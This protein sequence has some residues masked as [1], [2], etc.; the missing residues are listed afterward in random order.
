MINKD[1]HYEVHI[2]NQ[3]HW[4][5]TGNFEVFVGAEVENLKDMPLELDGK[6]LPKTHYARLT[7]KGDEIKT[8]ESKLADVLPSDKYPQAKFNGMQFIIQ[9]YDE[10][11]KGLDRMEESEME[12]LI[13]LEKGER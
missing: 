7:V 4:K 1:T 11:F 3:E 8:W 10:R 2:W 6:A 12:I 5:E 9:C 13:P